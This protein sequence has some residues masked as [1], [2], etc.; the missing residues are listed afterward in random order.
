MHLL[1]K[2]TGLFPIIV[3]PG[4][5]HTHSSGEG[6]YHSNCRV[7]LELMTSCLASRCFNPCTSVLLIEVM[8]SPGIRPDL[9]AL[10]PGVTCVC[11]CM[12]VCVCVC[13]HVCVCV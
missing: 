9:S 3:V 8:Q 1:F 13:V 10:P 2:L 5:T 11:V 7:E 4:P 6:A 12:C